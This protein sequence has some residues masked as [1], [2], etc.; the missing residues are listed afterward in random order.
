MATDLLPLAVVL[1]LFGAVATV[2]AVRPRRAREMP[3][4]AD[5]SESNVSS[6]PLGITATPALPVVG[7]AT[8]ALTTIVALAIAAGVWQGG[9]GRLEIGGWG[10]PLGIALEADGLSAALLIMANLV[11]LC[12]SV[13]ATSYFGAS[14]KQLHFWPLWLLLWA[15]LNG[16][17]LSADLFNLYVMLE[18]V[19]LAAA[20]LGA[21]TGSR[22]AVAA[23]L[24]Y[25]LV[26]LLGSMTYLLGV[27][28]MYAAHGELDIGLLASALRDASQAG[29]VDAVALALM[30][31]GLALKAAL[32]PLH[33]WLPPAHANAPA[34]VSAALS[35]LVVKAAVYLILR[36]WLS[37][38][39]PVTTAAAALLLGLLGA[40]A[41]LW[42][43]WRALRAERLKL[44]AAYS[45]VAQ[46]GYLF[47]FFPL[48]AAT[49]PGPAYDN[50]VA[51]LVLMA[52][53]HGFAKA[54]LFLA[55]GSIQQSAGHDRVDQL[56]GTAQRL[57][58]TIFAIGLAGIAL[59]GLPP[60]G[61]FI[62]KWLLMQG[63]IETGQWGWI[64]VVLAGTLLAAAYVFR[65]LIRAFGLEPTPLHFVT[66]ARVEI[67]ALLLALVAVAVLGL[68]SGPLWTLLGFDGGRT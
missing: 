42:G 62:G 46:I 34:P 49:P 68:G 24:R 57:P 63:A 66:D 30:T 52:L 7:I 50:L 27:A 64:V 61:S 4:S 9:P 23:N 59:I 5:G 41:V 44:L 37:L 65:V 38:F 11:A 67:P 31:G 1:P 36:L 32:F 10:V 55:A 15:A 39:A 33:F 6:G 13:Y 2:V 53:T 12:T 8:A 29:P 16:L 48:L 35:A 51:A 45:T 25:L 28:L 18:L 60:S 54:G 17:F 19:G 3:G 22:E 47:L 43:S 58:A 21:L 26:G 14:D 20:A 40:A 56:G